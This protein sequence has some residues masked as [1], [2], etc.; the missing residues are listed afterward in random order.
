MQHHGTR[1]LSRNLQAPLRCK[2]T[3]PTA[4]YTCT[5]TVTDACPTASTVTETLALTFTYTMTEYATMAV[6]PVARC[7]EACYSHASGTLAAPALITTT[8]VTICEVY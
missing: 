1:A 4:V 3:S 2:Y 7:R 8:I 5:S 6:A